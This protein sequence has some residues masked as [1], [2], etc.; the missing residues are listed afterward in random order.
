MQDA[1]DLRII[2]DQLWN[3]VEARQRHVRHAP[4]HDNA[5]VRSERARGP[6]YLLS[7]LL[8]CGVCGGGFSK[9]SLH[10]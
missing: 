6:V 10:H 7:N 9:V 3:E 5:G 4:T 1:P 2:D 8:R